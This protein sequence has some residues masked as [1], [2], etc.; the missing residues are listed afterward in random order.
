MTDHGKAS[1]LGTTI[2]LTKDMKTLMRYPHAL[3][4]FVALT[5]TACDIKV[6][7]DNKI[8]SDNNVPISLLGGPP[9]VNNYVPHST[10][11]STQSIVPQSLIDAENVR[12]TTTLQS[13]RGDTVEVPASAS[14]TLDSGAE[15]TVA[16]IPETPKPASKPS[17]PVVNVASSQRAPA[18][19]GDG[20]STSGMR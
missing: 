16:R 14:V 7:S 12:V 3:V 1:T 6:A 10:V 17:H 9:T 19:G 20:P 18:S 2:A 13:M 5:Q 11:L 8:A 4:L 15:I